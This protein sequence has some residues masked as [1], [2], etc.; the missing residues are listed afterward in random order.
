MPASFLRQTVSILFVCSQLD[1]IFSSNEK[2]VSWTPLEGAGRFILPLESKWAKSRET[3]LPRVRDTA[4]KRKGNDCELPATCLNRVWDWEKEQ[5]AACCQALEETKS[6]FW[7]IKEKRF[8]PFKAS[9]LTENEHRNNNMPARTLWER[10]KLFINFL[11]AVNP[12]KNYF[13]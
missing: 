10:G 8:L 11:I 2:R 1:A 12:P 7:V 13:K 6:R 9:N 5:E 3:A 4:G